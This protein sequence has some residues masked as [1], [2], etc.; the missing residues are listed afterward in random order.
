MSNM[1]T[2]RPVVELSEPAATRT[3]PAR[4]PPPG[5]WL[6]LHAGC[7]PEEVEAF[8]ANL[9]ANVEVE[10]PGSRDQVVDALLGEDP[11]LAA[12]GLRLED[13]ATGASL[14]P[15]CCAGLED[16]REWTS[17]LDGGAPWLGHDPRPE[18]EMRG[19]LLRAWQHGGPRRHGP[20]VDLTRAGLAELLASAQADLVGFLDR[21]DHWA[22]DS[23][24]GARGAALV[25]AVDRDFE[26]TT[27]LTLPGGGPGRRYLT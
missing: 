1:L 25:A 15:G 21:L 14:S 18:I 20:Y 3:W 13:S 22:R 23:G 24:L 26:I 17:A 6:T 10:P 8:L 16:W 19:E 9:A 4:T 5:G 27:P 12:G 7:P 11:L 2:L